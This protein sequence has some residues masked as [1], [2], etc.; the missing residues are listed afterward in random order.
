MSNNIK[1]LPVTIYHKSLFS[2]F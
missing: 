1:R 2:L